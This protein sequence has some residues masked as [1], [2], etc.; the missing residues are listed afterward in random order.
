MG[1]GRYKKRGCARKKRSCARMVTKKIKK[2]S[3]H[4]DDHDDTKSPFVTK[5]SP[6]ASK[7][8]PNASPQYQTSP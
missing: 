5:H 8:D 2:S 7:V 1:Y 3:V 4:P 6:W